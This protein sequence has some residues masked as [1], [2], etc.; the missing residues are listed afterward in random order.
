MKALLGV[1]V[2][3]LL[4]AGGWYVY[5]HKSAPS[6]EDAAE[7]Q[8][9]T[10]SDEATEAQTAPSTAA[11]LNGSANQTNTRQATVAPVL[12]LGNSATLGSY[13]VAGNGMTLY[14]YTKDTNGVSNCS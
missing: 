4:A 3:V 5:A 1:V 11:G 14:T 7:Y 13:L 10:P 2:V 8:A 12:A 6:L 9:G